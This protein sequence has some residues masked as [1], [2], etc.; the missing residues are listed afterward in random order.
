MKAYVYGEGEAV[1]DVPAKIVSQTL[2]I[3]D[4]TDN[5][6]ATGYIDF[7]TNLPANAV[8]LGWKAEVSAGFTGDTSATMQVG[9]SGDLDKFSGSTAADCSSTGTIGA[10]ANNDAVLSSSAQ[11]PRV[12]V[13]GGSDFGSITAGS[14][15]VTLYYLPMD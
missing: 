12:T 11:T 4:F 3:G 7:D 10:P 13:T 5:E 14:M 6:D 8:P 15:V 1:K 9:I 2:K